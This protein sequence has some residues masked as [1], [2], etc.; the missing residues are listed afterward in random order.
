MLQPQS[1]VLARLPL[2][3]RFFQALFLLPQPSL[4]PVSPALVASKTTQPDPLP[5]RRVW[6]L[7]QAVRN[8]Q[9]L[10]V[11]QVAA[12][13]L[14]EC[15][16]VVFVLGLG[17]VLT[18][19]ASGFSPQLS[20]EPGWG[21]ARKADLAAQWCF[22]LSRYQLTFFRLDQAAGTLLASGSVLHPCFQLLPVVDPAWRFFEC[23][24]ERSLAAVPVTAAGCS[25]AS[26]CY[27]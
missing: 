2:A 3:E 24:H 12:W 27:Q 16:V 9:R 6:F 1:W 5:V 10:P 20:P 13:T 25:R 22:C 17:P 23:Q 18:L 4:D 8:W 14:P 7:A 21:L 19:V 11:L 26:Y 15:R